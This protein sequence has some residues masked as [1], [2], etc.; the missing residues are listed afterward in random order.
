MYQLSTQSRCSATVSECQNK[1]AS[2]TSSSDSGTSLLPAWAATQPSGFGAG[3]GAGRL[4]H[5]RRGYEL[6]KGR[7]VEPEALETAK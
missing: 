1:N 5:V 7:G 4:Q 3:L 6:G 2:Q